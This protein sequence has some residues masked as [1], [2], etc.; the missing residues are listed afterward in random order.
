MLGLAGVLP[1]FSQPVLRLKNQDVARRQEDAARLKSLQ[2]WWRHVVVQFPA[3]PTAAEIR[4]LSERGAKILRPVPDYGLLVSVNDLA[5]L[6]NLGAIRIEELAPARKISPLLHTVDGPPSALLVEFHPDVDRADATSIALQDAIEVLQHPD[7]PPTYMLVRGEWR[8]MEALS[9][10]DEVAYIL[11]AS[12]ELVEGEPVIFCDGGLTQLGG[13]GQYVETFGSGWDGAGQGPTTLT[14]SLEKPT[15][16]VPR[17]VLVRELERALGEWSRYIRVDFYPSGSPSGHR[18]INFLFASGGH[19]D[20][21]PFDGPG[22]TLAHAFYPAP[23]NPESIAG[24]VHFDDAEVWQVGVGNDLFSVAL[25]ELGHAIGLGHSDDPGAVMYPHYRLAAQLTRTDV[26]AIQQLYA[27][28][29]PPPL[30]VFELVIEEPSGES[31]TESS[32]VR[33]L[34]SVLGGGNEVTVTWKDRA[35]HRGQA[36]GSRV[37]TVPALPLVPGFNRI[38]VTATDTGGLNAAKSITVY[39]IPTRLVGPFHPGPG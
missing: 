17:E 14:Y 11:P 23:P 26:E 16:Q 15:E 34:G 37:W 29:A 30:P 1:A 9:Q 27:A 24:D 38:T 12:A 13:I 6:S 8:H 28:A 3:A 21:Y 5:G 19:G 36:I 22:R 4:I 2:P 10:W 35:G 20:G 18:N 7:L 25:H 33:L 31:M 39:R 32:T